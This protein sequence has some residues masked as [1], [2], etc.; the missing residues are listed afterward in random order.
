MKKKINFA[1]QSLNPTFLVS[2]KYFQAIIFG[3]NFEMSYILNR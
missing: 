1:L 2:E 3:K